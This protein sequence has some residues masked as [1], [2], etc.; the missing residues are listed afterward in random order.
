MTDPSDVTG[1]PQLDE[2]PSYDN[3]SATLVERD[4]VPAD[5][6]DPDAA[7]FDAES[8]PDGCA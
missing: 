6:F 2:F 4:E 1:G 7:D 3:R 8:D 5:S